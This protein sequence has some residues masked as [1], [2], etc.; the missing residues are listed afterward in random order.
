MRVRVLLTAVALV[1]AVPASAQVNIES[2]LVGFT[3]SALQASAGY[4]AMSAACQAEFAATRMCSTQEILETRRIPSG[5]D[6]PAWVRP[7]L[8]VTGNQGVGLDVTGTPVYKACT[9]APGVLMTVSATGV[10]SPF[11]NCPGA[12]MPVAC[13]GLPID[14]AQGDLDQDGAATALDA[15]IFRRML[16]GQPVLLGSGP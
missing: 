1:A 16:A 5:L 13:C 10:F 6:G 8:A 2:V 3:S 9:S 15:T 7:K 14:P 4:L 12:Q 11:E